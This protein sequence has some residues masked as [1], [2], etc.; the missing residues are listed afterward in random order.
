MSTF[1]VSCLRGSSL[2]LPHPG[3]NRNICHFMGKTRA[4]GGNGFSNYSSDSVTGLAFKRPYCREND[5]LQG[6][7]CLLPSSWKGMADHVPPRLS[8]GSVATVLTVALPNC[9]GR[10]LSSRARA[11]E[12]RPPQTRGPRFSTPVYT[13][14]Y[15]RGGQRELGELTSLSQHASGAVSTHAAEGWGGHS[16]VP[17]S[18]LEPAPRCGR[19]SVPL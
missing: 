8:R 2:P 14:R 12:G 5:S 10:K 13:G 9:H 3:N 4:P 1:T 6:G 7:H 15:L 17:W 19:M 11:E 18:P 16:L